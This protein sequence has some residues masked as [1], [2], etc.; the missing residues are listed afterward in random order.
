MCVCVRS[1]ECV[2]VLVSAEHAEEVWLHHPL[3][4]AF[5]RRA[6]AANGEPVPQLPGGHDLSLTVPH[7]AAGR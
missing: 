7:G 5:P 1:V 6:A 3:V 4:S 2:I